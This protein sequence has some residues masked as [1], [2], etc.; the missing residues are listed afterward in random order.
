MTLK[1][2][3]RALAEEAYLATPNLQSVVSFIVDY[4][5]EKHARAGAGGWLHLYTSYSYE[6]HDAA[7]SVRWRQGHH[8]AIR[9]T[10]AANDAE[11]YERHA[12]RAVH[13][14][15]IPRWKPPEGFFAFCCK[16]T[17]DQTT[18]PT[19]RHSVG[20]CTGLTLPFHD[21]FIFYDS[22]TAYALDQLLNVYYIDNGVD[23]SDH[24]LRIEQME[25]PV[26]AD[27]KRSRRITFTHGGS[28][29]FDNDLQ[30]QGWLGWIFA[31]YVCREICRRL[32][33]DPA[34]YGRPQH[35]WPDH[36]LR[37][38]CYHLDMAL[39]ELADVRDT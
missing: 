11:A 7:R 20:N 18:L 2:G 30:R 36:D 27:R 34:T 15:G 6:G 38:Y 31:S 39:W 28:P 10:L 23:G 16:F 29:R 14:L 1:S 26:P 35:V 9:Q 33:A 21:V 8:A 5:H 4:V 12:C 19:F 22:R 24:P 32:N 37:W 25:L 13:F 3:H 17:D